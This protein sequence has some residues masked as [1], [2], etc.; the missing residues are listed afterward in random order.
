MRTYECGS[1]RRAES[2]HVTALLS[3]LLTASPPMT[4]RAPGMGR[5]PID[6]RAATATLERRDQNYNRE[7]RVKV[8]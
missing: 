6:L 2:G 5:V 3:G 8:R 4:A 1:L 7:G